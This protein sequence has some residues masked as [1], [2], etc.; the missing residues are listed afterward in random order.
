MYFEFLQIRNNAEIVV[1]SKLI[2]GKTCLYNISNNIDKKLLTQDIQYIYHKLNPPT[3]E[4]GKYFMEVKYI[5][6]YVQNL[7]DKNCNINLIQ[8][9]MKL[10]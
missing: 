3:V 1:L 5:Y 9:L 8:M 10:C 2:N 6:D 4:L 7:K